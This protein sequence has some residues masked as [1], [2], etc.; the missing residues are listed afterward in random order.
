MQASMTAMQRAEYR[1]F[2]PYWRLMMADALTRTGRTAAAL[3]AVE[4]ALLLSSRTG[5]AWLDAELHRQKGNLLLQEA[6]SKTTMAES[7]FQTAMTVSRCQRA[8]FF[9]LRAVTDLARI[10]AAQG[11]RTDARRLLQHTCSWFDDATSAPDFTHANELLAELATN[12]LS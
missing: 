10:W 5:E 6:T 2:G 11:K 7:S 4:E 9:E 1:A 12:F 8:K 3:G